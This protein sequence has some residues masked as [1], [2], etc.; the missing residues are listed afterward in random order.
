MPTLDQFQIDNNSKPISTQY[1]NNLSII[2]EPQEQ[3]LFLANEHSTLSYNM[4]NNS[5]FGVNFPVGAL[6]M[7]T[8]L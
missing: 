3:A 2:R 6:E 5:T 7:N 1:M 4:D 8:V